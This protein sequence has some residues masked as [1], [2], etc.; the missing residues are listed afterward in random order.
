MK[1]IKGLKLFILLLLAHFSFADEG[2]WLPQLL[3]QLNEKQMKSLG[4]KINASDIYN[5]NKGSLKDAIVSFGGFCTG[6]VISDKGLVLTNHHCGFDAIQDHSSITHNYIRD[7]FWAKNHG[8]ELPNPGL[9]VTFIIRIDDVTSAALS[10][11][12]RNMTEPERQ[13]AVDKNLA[14]LRKNY[15]KE[16]YQDILIRPFYEG[17][18]YYLFVT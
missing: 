11:V 15:K 7:G 5:I 8:E 4:M 2:M 17:N 6:E 1:L 13:S 14:E 16:E 18:K 10:G 12:S 9:F 3:E